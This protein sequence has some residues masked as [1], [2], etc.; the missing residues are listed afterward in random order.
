MLDEK[1]IAVTVHCEA[2]ADGED[3]VY[4]IYPSTVCPITVRRR[5]RYINMHDL[6]NCSEA[7]H[8]KGRKP[9]KKL[10]LK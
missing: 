10:A 3:E 9:N 7:V 2:T 5:C 8:I 6:R 4:D 1:N